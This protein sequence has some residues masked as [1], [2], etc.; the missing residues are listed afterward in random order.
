MTQIRNA[1]IPLRIKNVKNPNGSGTIIYPFQND[2]ETSKSTTPESSVEPLNS[3]KHNVSS[4]MSANGYY[5]KDRNRR[6]PTALT[7]KDSII[8]LNVA[9]LRQ[10]KSHGFLARVF[11]KLDELHIVTD[12]ITSSEQSISLALSSTDDALQ[13]EQLILSLE[14]IGKV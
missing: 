12:L 3:L 10:S 4:F 1:N 14:R 13:I 5:G 9:S 7:M 11:A 6:T 2:E 8:L